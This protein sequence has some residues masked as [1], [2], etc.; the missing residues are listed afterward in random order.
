MFKK[1]KN[2]D[3]TMTYYF[4]SSDIT[5]GIDIFSWTGPRNPMGT[6]PPSSREIKQRVSGI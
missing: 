2:D 5:R 3:G 4:M 1:V 6:P